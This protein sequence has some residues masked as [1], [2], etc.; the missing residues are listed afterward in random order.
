MSRR[1]V[2]EE[3]LC[4]GQGRREV[5]GGAAGEAGDFK[6]KDNP[7]PDAEALPGLRER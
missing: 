1:Q 7:V 3:Q 2:R 6:C 4:I 5:R